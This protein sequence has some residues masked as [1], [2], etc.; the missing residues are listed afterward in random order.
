MVIFH[1]FLYV[2]QRVCLS[3]KTHWHLTRFF[4]IQAIHRQSDCHDIIVDRSHLSK[5]IDIIWTSYHT[6]H[7]AL[8]LWSM[9]LITYQYPSLSILI[10]LIIHLSMPKSA[11]NVDWSYSNTR[12]TYIWLN[13]KYFKRTWKKVPKVW[14]YPYF[15]PVVMDDHDLVS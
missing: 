5:C 13:Y 15:H 10:V 7:T 12:D 4:S 6:Y 14:D 11:K 9:I 2:Y 1:S 8:I 3:W